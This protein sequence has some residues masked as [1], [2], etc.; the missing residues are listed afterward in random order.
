MIAWII[1]A[2]AHIYYL[3]E[4]DNKLVVM[5]QWAWNYITLGRGAR[6]ITKT[7]A[8]L[9]IEPPQ[10]LGTEPVSV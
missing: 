1:W 6:L 2:F 7:P 5:I 4:F 8:Q 9:E 10:K 3:I